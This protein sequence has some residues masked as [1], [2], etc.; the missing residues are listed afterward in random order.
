M[1]IAV[2]LSA[3]APASAA[4]VADL[5]TIQVP[6]DRSESDW[7]EQAY[8]RAL[9]QVL[10]RVTGQRTAAGDPALEAL[11]EDPT[12]LVQG[13]R[14]GAEETLWVSFDGRAIAARL[15]EAGRAVWG[16]ERPVTL[17][18]LAV[19][20]GGG[21]RDL[22]AA[23]DGPAP[24]AVPGRSTRQLDGA[25]RD[26]F[27]RQ[28]VEDVA[29]AR[30]LPFV[31]PLLD[32][33][34]RGSVAFSDVWGGFEQPVLEA[35]SRYG[36][37]SILLGR[38]DADGRQLPRWTWYFGGEQR[39]WRASIEDAVHR[40]ADLMAGQLAAV[41][42]ERANPVRLTVTGVEDLAAY[43]DISRY[44]TSVSM[45]RDLRLEQLADNALTYRL[46][47]LGASDRLG[48]VLRLSG[49]FGTLE[50]VVDPAATGGE[51]GAAGQVREVPDLTVAY[52]P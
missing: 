46:E 2:V 32:A 50:E 12:R 6:A 16:S 40:V 15:R 3:A 5:Y 48:R 44:L 49:R 24:A 26:G 52:R 36:A 4:E 33:Q 23:E 11:F 29:R 35:S 31:W 42:D 30:G 28:R 8:R 21:D 13:Y 10:V 27:L 17:L 19:D 18:W 22:I 20:R 43:A 41:G 25:D 45:I 38:I 37:N 9:S 51:V 34:D 7:R 39:Q 1:A 14:R 47:L